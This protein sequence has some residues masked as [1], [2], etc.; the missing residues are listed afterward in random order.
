MRQ[1]GLKIGAGYPNAKSRCHRDCPICQPDDPTKGSARI[2]GKKVLIEEL[3]EEDEG[4]GAVL[5]E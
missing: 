4:K 2:R 5:E 1:Y 3:R